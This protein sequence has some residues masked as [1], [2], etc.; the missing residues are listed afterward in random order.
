MHVRLLAVLC[1]DVVEGAGLRQEIS[2][3]ADDQMQLHTDRQHALNQVR[4]HT[5]RFSSTIKVL[6][7]RMMNYKRLSW[8]P[9]LL[10]GALA[11]GDFQHRQA[12][13]HL[14]SSGDLCSELHCSATVLLHALCQCLG[15][16][17]KPHSVTSC[18]A[19]DHGMG[20]VQKVKAAV[21]GTSL[22]RDKDTGH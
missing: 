22:R 17:F 21:E 19:T 1:N 20:N 14:V 7:H 13:S 5:M 15:S 8:C 18:P 12:P 16:T 3:R 4:P 6:A 10:S 9:V 11:R 2:M